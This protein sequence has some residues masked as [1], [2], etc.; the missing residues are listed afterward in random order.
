MSPIRQPAARQ[1]VDVSCTNLQHY[2]QNVTEMSLLLLDTSVYPSLENSSKFDFK[3]A[4]S[5]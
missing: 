4:I 2:S 1:R 5:V 3:T